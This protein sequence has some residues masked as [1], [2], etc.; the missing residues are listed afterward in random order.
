MDTTIDFKN[1]TEEEWQQRLTPEQY[2][3]LRGAGTE[4]AFTGIYDEE[5]GKGSY[6]CAAC[7]LKLFK[8][9]NKYNSGCG[10]PAFDQAIPD[11]IIYI[12]DHTFGMK[13]TEVRCSRCKSHL[14]HVFPDGPKETTGERYC[15]N[16]ASLEMKSQEE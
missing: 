8:S 12:D 10:W 6:H 7:G 2:R 16:S 5:F 3:I 13:R 11:T 14:G 4:T 15:I 9:D 1:L